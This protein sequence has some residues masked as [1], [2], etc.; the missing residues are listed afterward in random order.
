MPT[1]N[2]ALTVNHIDGDKSNNAASNLEWLTTGDNTRHAYRTGICKHRK[3]SPSVA[4]TIR[5]EAET[6]SVKLLA[7]NYGVSLT[8]IYKILN[9]K[10]YKENKA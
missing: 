9:N 4:S 3:L 1:N 5:T 8:A 6:T 2:E 10:S 7:S